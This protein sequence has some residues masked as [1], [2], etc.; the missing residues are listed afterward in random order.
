[1]NSP[2]GIAAI[3]AEIL[4]TGLLQVRIA[5][6]SG[7]SSLAAKLADH[8]HNLPNLLSD[9]SQEMLTFYWDVERPSFRDSVDDNI[10]KPYIDLWA[11]LEQHVLSNQASIVHQT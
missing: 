4:R 10:V 6:W 7:D 8:L 1:V 9:F 5:G 2:Q 3:V 11:Q